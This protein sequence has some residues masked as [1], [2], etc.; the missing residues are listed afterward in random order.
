MALRYLWGAQG[1]A[2]GRSFIRFITYVAIGG[3]TVGVAALLLALSIVRG[4]SQE[5]EDK[6]V[7]FGA[8]V[9]VRSFLQDAPLEPMRQLEDRLRQMEGVA[10]VV[11]VAEHFVLLRRSREAIDGVALFG[12]DEPPAYLKKRTVA[13]S[14]SFAPDSLRR[15]GLVL[16]QQLADR[17]SLSVGDVVTAFSMDDP[18][19]AEGSLLQPRVKQFHV[20][21]IFETSLSN[22]DDL[23]VFTGLQPARELIGMSPDAVTHFDLTLRDVS[24]ADSVA[25]RV[26]REFGFPVGAQTIYE[27]FQGLFAWVNLQQGIIPLVISVIIIV[28]AFNIIGALL[29]MILEKTREIGVLE[30]LGASARTMRRLYLTIGLLIGCVGTLLG[31]GIALGLGLI[32]QRYGIIPLPAEAYYM[33][34][35]PV[36]LNPLD[37]VL[38]AG[39]ALALCAVAAYVPA[40]VASR[41][42]PV[43]A[44]RFE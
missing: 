23:Y 33:K 5:I 7:G 25:A 43:E 32:Q 40:R 19:S 44:I 2:E 41:I 6:I 37:F 8:H 34:T 11:P 16:G 18:D 22:I 36:E 17:L 3:V 42:E 21:G 26:E 10:S 4:F 1:R 9:Q 28:A 15:P 27:R 31:E 12:A 24:R 35:A 20:A 29:M 14:F 39:V 30:S 13:G 38:V